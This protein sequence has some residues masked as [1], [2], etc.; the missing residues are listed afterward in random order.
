MSA[1]QLRGPGILRVRIEVA[2]EHEHQLH[3][4]SRRTTIGE[5]VTFGALQA[6][7]R[8]FGESS[9]RPG[10][11]TGLGENFAMWSTVSALELFFRVLRKDLASARRV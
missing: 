10:F 3:I 11:R 1:Q 5:A 6:G 2:A 9:P 4:E 7:S 8:Q